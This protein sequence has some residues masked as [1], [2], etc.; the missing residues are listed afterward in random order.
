[1]SDRR[2][3]TRY[4]LL[5]DYLLANGFVVHEQTA[6]GEEGFVVDAEFYGPT[7]DAAV[8]SLEKPATPARTK[9]RRTVV[10]IRKENRTNARERHAQK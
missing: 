10:E 6:V 3:A 1:L 7:F 2:D 8:D 4:R 9:Q 5:R